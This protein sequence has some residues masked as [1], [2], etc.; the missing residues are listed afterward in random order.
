MPPFPKHKI[1]PPWAG[2]PMMFGLLGL[3]ATLA[4][5]FLAVT[6]QRDTVFVDGKIYFVD[7]DCYSRMTRV[8]QFLAHPLR[9]IR[10]HDFENFPAG[11]DTHTT[12][13]LDALIAALAILF[14]PISAQPL[15]LAGAWIS[16]LL[17]L[18]ALLGL[19]LW[20]TRER[21]PFRGA[22]VLLV[23]I[24]PVA[25]QAFRLGRPDHQSLLLFLLA[26]G[27]A[28]EWSLW[29]RAS[30]RL[31][32][33][34]GLA[35]G[36][37]LWTSLYEPLIVFGFLFVA[38]IAA[39]RRASFT[40]TWAIGWAAL[41]GVVI[42]ALAFDGWRV[43]QP[44]PEVA[45]YFSRWAKSIGEL[46]T[47]SPVSSQFPGWLG[48]LAPALPFLLAWRFARLRDARLLAIL[49]LLLGA[50]ALTCGQIRWGC[51]L[52]LI[53]AMSL[54]FA[55]AAVPSRALAWTA[56]AFSLLPIAS[57]WDALTN[58][59]RN[60]LAAIAEQRADYAQLREVATALIS[61][62]RTPILAPWWLSPPLAYWSGQ[63]C[64][65]GSSHESLPGTIDSARFYMA[66]NFDAAR[67]IAR[68][69]RVAYVVAY[70]PDRVL[71]TSSPLLGEPVSR[72]ALAAI[73]YHAPSVAPPW[74][75]P[76]LRT[77]YFRVFAV[78]DPPAR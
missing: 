49:A 59:D 70:E 11:V 4:L 21:L 57:Q 37:A 53:A 16:P 26:A 56:F 52:A 20:A 61:N 51:Y 47:L 30:A 35:W 22:M 42:I 48:W 1:W 50:Y 32:V 12:A 6:A 69:R 18:A 33:A 14:R 64:V 44:S 28:A 72:H 3:T 46:A 74:L 38:R 2:R 63:P 73:L 55:L 62:E 66:T 24:S 78:N 58:P 10:H 45:E 17:G 76:V 43:H 9:S 34:W 29:Q 77:P 7:A 31:A 23:A 8:E 15:D 27:L 36:V 5:Y 19:W 13:P 25:A 54:P 75:R 71:G 39:L 68:R 67:E 40:R 65:A 41:G 60:R